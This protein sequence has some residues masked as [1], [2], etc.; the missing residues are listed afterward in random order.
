[1]TNLQRKLVYMAQIQAIRSG[2]IV[3]VHDSLSP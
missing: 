3:L 1:M 2:L